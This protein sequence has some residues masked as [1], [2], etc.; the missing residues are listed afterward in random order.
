MASANV[1]LVRSIFDEWQHGDFDSAAWAD[2]C[3]AFVLADGP[4]P[5]SWEGLDGM[6]EGWRD[7]LGAWQH[8]R[9]EAEHYRELDGE[10]VLVLIHGTGR[11]KASGLDAAQVRS[12]GA[13]LF[14]ISGGRVKRLVVYFNRE[15]AFTDL[16]LG[17][18]AGAAD[19]RD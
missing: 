12:E 6:I 13:N 19:A 9:G 4:S 5:G 15:R 10:R 7:F 18:E 11:G 14:H 8:W 16:G 3:I 2:P 17:P 1:D